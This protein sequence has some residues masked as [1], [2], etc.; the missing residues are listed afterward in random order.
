M[1]D[2]VFQIFHAAVYTIF[3]SPDAMPGCRHAAD[4]LMPMF[5]AMPAFSMPSGYFY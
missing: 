5:F 4:A 2:I 1:P 3:F